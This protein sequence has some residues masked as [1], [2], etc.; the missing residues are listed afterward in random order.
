VQVTRDKNTFLDLQFANI[1]LDLATILG[2]ANFVWDL[3]NTIC[4]F[5]NF[6]E[7]CT[8]FSDVSIALCALKFFFFGF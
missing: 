5:N 1:F 3:Q 7:I 6:I 8:S 2:F 4:G